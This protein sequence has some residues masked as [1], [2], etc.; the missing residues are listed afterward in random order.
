ME[1]LQVDLALRAVQRHRLD[2]RVL[3]LPLAPAFVLVILHSPANGSAEGCVHL[4][5]LAVG[6]QPGSRWVECCDRAEDVAGV[7]GPLEEL[8]GALRVL[9]RVL[10]H[11]VH[12][13]Q[14]MQIGAGL[15]LEALGQRLLGVEHVD[16]PQ[17]LGQCLAFAVDELI[18]DQC[19][20]PCVAADEDN[21]H[22]TVI[23]CLR[24]WLLACTL[25][26]GCN[27]LSEPRV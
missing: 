25:H 18:Q 19:L 9:Q 6:S 2:V 24:P 20:V 21:A 1:Q 12:R 22:V 8:A 7:G 11:H 14:L 3:A 16:C 15:T 26:T 27:A 5:L 23:Q 17:L 4:L 10:R 13:F